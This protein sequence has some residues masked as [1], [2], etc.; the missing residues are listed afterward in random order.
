MEITAF[1][2]FMSLLPTREQPRVE[3]GNTDTR[4]EMYFLFF[5]KKL[6]LL[7]TCILVLVLKNI[8]NP[9]MPKVQKKQIL[10][11]WCANKL[12]SMLVYSYSARGVQIEKR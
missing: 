11:V 6:E 10:S 7:C 4:H 3:E 9:K 5:Q 12:T 8:D 2:K 1:G